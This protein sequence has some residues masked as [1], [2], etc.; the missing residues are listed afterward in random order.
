MV[1]TTYDAPKFI[2]KLYNKEK[3]IVIIL[4]SNFRFKTANI[5]LQSNQYFKA[6][7]R[8]TTNK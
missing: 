2:I 3:K 5:W 7:V 4:K 6:W 1:R 8:A